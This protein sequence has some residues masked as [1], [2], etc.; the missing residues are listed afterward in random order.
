VQKS[1]EGEGTEGERERAKLKTRTAQLQTN[2]L[3]TS[4]LDDKAYTV[5]YHLEV[6]VK[7]EIVPVL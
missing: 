6:Q 7:G 2:V 5:H 1:N 3:V 4:D